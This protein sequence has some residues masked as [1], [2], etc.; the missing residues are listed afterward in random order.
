VAGYECHG[1]LFKLVVCLY[2]DY[3]YLLGNFAGFTG[4]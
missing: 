1:R 3:S 4:F 2:V